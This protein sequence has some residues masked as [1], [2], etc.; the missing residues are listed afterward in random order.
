MEWSR[1]VL[2]R[3]RDRESRPDDAQESLK[4]VAFPPAFPPLV[5]PLAEG[6]CGLSG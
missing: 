3:R 6:L 5:K 4:V 2:A 1:M